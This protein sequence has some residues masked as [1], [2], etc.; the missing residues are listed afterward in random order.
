[1][2]R[3]T[4]KPR[5]VV[6]IHAPVDDGI[7]DEDDE[8]PAPETSALPIIELNQNPI[9]A[10]VQSALKAANIRVRVMPGVFPKESL[11]VMF[12][13]AAILQ[14]QLGRMVLDALTLGDKRFSK[15]VAEAIRKID[16]VFLRHWNKAILEKAHTF[17]E[18]LPEPRPPVEEIKKRLEEICNHKFSAHD[19]SRLR[20]QLML[21]KQAPKPGPGRG[22]R[23][24]TTV[25]EPRR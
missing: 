15:V 7:V 13:N 2:K 18:S 21:P 16:P 8:F 24:K 25:I 5:L 14:Q 3:N 10:A 12:G 23:K 22:N 9:V 1:M 11:D 17:V 19:W 20:K 4:K 6:H